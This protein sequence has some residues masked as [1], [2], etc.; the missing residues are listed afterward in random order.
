MCQL[1]GKPTCRVPVISLKLYSVEHRPGAETVSSKEE[2][3]KRKERE[4]EKR[5]W[6][7]SG[8]GQKLFTKLV[9]LGKPLSLPDPSSLRVLIC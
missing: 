7:G 3:E 5:E 4:E 1:K 8:R 9:A 6:S 2:R